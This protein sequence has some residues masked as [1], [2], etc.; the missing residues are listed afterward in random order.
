MS[1]YF[2]NLI[3]HFKILLLTE[4]NKYRKPKEKFK[5][6]FLVENQLFSRFK[7]LTT[8]KATY[9][10]SIEIDFNDYLCSFI[11]GKL[12]FADFYISNVD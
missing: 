12:C 8:E 6:L 7:K 2:K 4:F 5:K 9:G 11:L 10:Y 1:S 3:S